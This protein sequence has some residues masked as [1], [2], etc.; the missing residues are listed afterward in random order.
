MLRL[1]NQS[2]S[3]YEFSERI[4]IKFTQIFK[5]TVPNM[6]IVIIMKRIDDHFKIKYRS[7]TFF[8]K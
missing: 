4:Y 5:K 2:T 8:N 7:E 1:L 6:K 3:M